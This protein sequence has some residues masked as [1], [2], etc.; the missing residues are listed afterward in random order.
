MK[1]VKLLP[2]NE[3]GHSEL[4]ECL[5]NNSLATLNRATGT[6]KS[7]IVLKYLYENRKKRILIVAPTYPI[8][9]QWTED[10]MTE[11]GINKSEFEKLDTMIYANMLKIDDMEKFASQYDIVIFD[12]YHRCGSKKWGK[13]VQQ[14]KEC[15]LSVSGKKII[16]TTATE[17]RYLDKERNMKDILFDGVEASRLS[18]ADAILQGILPAPYYI[19]FDF[20]TIEVVDSLIK[21]I[22]SGLPNYFEEKKPIIERLI[23]IRRE[24]ISDLFEDKQLKSFLKG[25]EKYLAFS[26]TKDDIK[27]DMEKIK[28]IFSD[29]SYQEFVVHSGQSK[30][31]NRSELD[32]FKSSKGK[33]S[34]IL[35]SIAILNEGVHVKDVSGIF[36]FR[37]TTSPIIYFQQLGRLLSFSRRKDRV[38]VFDYAGNLKNHKVIYKLYNEVISRAKELIETDPA[39]KERYL[40]IIENFKIVDKTSEILEK[41]NRY[42]EKYSKETLIKM[43]LEKDI[44]MVQNGK[45]LNYLTVYEIESDFRRYYKY[46]DK[47]LFVKIKN[48]K[49]IGKPN[50]FQLDVD[51]FVNLLDGYD[52]INDLL[53]NKYRISFEKVSKFIDDNYAIPSL[54][55]DDE[56]ELLL[57][58]ELY[59]NYKKYNSTMIKYIKNSIDYSTSLYERISYGGVVGE[60]DYDELFSEINSVIGLKQYINKNVINV[61]K[62]SIINKTYPNQKKMGSMIKK[63]N[64]YNKK[65]LL[66]NMDSDYMEKSFSSYVNTVAG[67]NSSLM[68]KTIQELQEQID[69]EGIDEV[70]KAAYLEIEG[71]IK[72]YGYL[73]TYKR[74]SS[75]SVGENSLSSLLACKLNVFEK[76]FDILGYMDK[77]DKVLLTVQVDANN[78]IVDEIIK[79]IENHNG[80]PPSVKSDDY[81]ESVLARYLDK[82]KNKKDSEAYKRLSP[83]IE[84]FNRKKSDFVESVNL[85]KFVSSEDR[86]FVENELQKFK[87]YLDTKQ[88]SLIES[89]KRLSSIINFMLSH[90][91]ELPSVKNA[92]NNESQ[93]AHMFS[94]MKWRMTPKQFEVLSE[95]LEKQK[96]YK[97]K[98]M[99]K[100]K[101]YVEEHGV[102]PRLFGNDEEC[103]LAKSFNRWEPYLSSEKIKEI[104]YNTIV[105]CLINFMESHNYELPSSKNLSGYEVDLAFSFSRIK[106][107]L[108]DENLIKLDSYNDKRNKYKELFLKKLKD[109]IAQD[110]HFPTKETNLELYESYNRWLP[111]LS[112][113]DV[114]VLKNE[115]NQ[116]EFLEFF[117][118]NNYEFPSLKNPSSEEQKMAHLYSLNRKFYD[119]L[120]EPYKSLIEESKQRFINDYVDFIN[121]HNRV[122]LLF[123]KA[124]SHLVYSYNRWLPYLNS[125]EFEKLKVKKVSKMKAL[126]NAYDMMR[127]EK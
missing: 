45:N 59:N 24:L 87:P 55:S 117:I 28:R 93:L 83:Y 41:L 34:S 103:N 4:V 49:K 36:M 91:Y 72:K 62:S 111:Y 112:N 65:L 43:R 10:H 21:R 97:I 104:S 42:N 101:L 22:S 46:V 14:L 31:H 127:K 92:D 108:D 125:D 69:K 73:P 96:E 102:L 47:D 120:V 100:Y 122:P 68:V 26:S 86:L 110:G 78:K 90:D 82:F 13:K 116:K 7:F 56:N 89:G 85:A 107:K 17:I 5:K 84:K 16:G 18:L 79:F 44:S 106:S 105:K 25:G 98:F 3:V 37:K 119:L 64:Q 58:I 113:N 123:E 94:Y 8:L 9:E 71:F 52:T 23:E 54:F 95:Y 29:I 19:S 40:S 35:Y 32:K 70:V 114:Y 53:N 6:G 1:K 11:L 33:L 81:D 48:L 67:E 99:E 15:I 121:T 30:E 66:S 39:N 74:F 51:E 61:L 109:F 80:F 115:I 12:E 126:E 63:I 60:I 20:E 50:L 2:H 77:I 76:A 88:I 38:Y 75:L 124:E 118:K 57:A 27:L